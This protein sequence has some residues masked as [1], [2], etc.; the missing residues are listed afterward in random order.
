MFE[1][2]IVILS[3]RQ[4]V[5]PEKKSSEIKTGIGL[6]KDFGTHTKAI[7]H[8]IEIYQ[9]YLKHSIILGF[10]KFNFWQ[11][12]PFVFTKSCRVFRHVTNFEKYFIYLLACLNLIF[13]V[14]I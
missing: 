13:I 7:S 11:F 9:L 4:S 2:G 3:S 8:K 6:N 10:R 14:L 5:F 12:W 1:L